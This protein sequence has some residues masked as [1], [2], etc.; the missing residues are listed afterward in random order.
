M[1]DVKQCILSGALEALTIDLSKRKPANVEYS[2]C[3]GPEIISNQSTCASP[4][5]ISDASVVENIPVYANSQVERTLLSPTIKINQLAKQNQHSTKS[6]SSSD[7]STTA[8]D[9]RNALHYSNDQI[10]QYSQK[11]KRT[12]VGQYP[13]VMSVPRLEDQMKEY[14]P[15]N[16]MSMKNHQRRLNPCSIAQSTQFFGG[17][18]IPYRDKCGK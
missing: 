17:L 2:V 16:D 9:T 8:Y 6:C 7:T 14:V 4:E 15:N 13:L 3:S 10:E 18:P 1:S 5:I 12:L 11:Y